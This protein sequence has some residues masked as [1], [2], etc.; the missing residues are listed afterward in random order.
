MLGTVVVTLTDDMWRRKILEAIVFATHSDH[1]TKYQKG[2]EIEPWTQ[3]K[4]Q[5]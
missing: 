2:M 3:N 4:K 5:T 1:A